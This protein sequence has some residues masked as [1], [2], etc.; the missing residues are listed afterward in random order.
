MKERVIDAVVENNLIKKGEN[1]LLGLSGGPDSMAL[2]YILKDIRE[3]IPF[4]LLAAH[5]NH[6][7]RGEDADNDENYVKDQCNKLNIPIYSQKINMNK[8]AKKNKLSSE[9]AGREIRYSF[10]RKTLDNIGGGK[11][12]VAHNKNDQAETLLMRFLRGTGIDGLR[13]MEYASNDII[14]P[15][16]DISRTEIEKYCRENEINPRIDKTNLEAIYGRNKIR[17]ELIPYIENNFNLG[18]IETLTRTARVMQ[19]ESDFLSEYTKEQFSEILIKENR[20]NIK[21]HNNKFIRLHKSIRSRVIRMG[22]ERL[23]GNLKGVEEKHVSDILDL[24]NSEN[25]GKR[26]NIGNNINIRISYKQ[27]IIEKNDKLKGKIEFHENLYLKSKL[28]IEELDM[29]IETKVI[30][31]E[32]LN[33]NSKDRFIKYFDYDKI[34]GDLS[35]R[36]RNPG[37]RFIPL[38]MKGSK[39]IKDFYID[40]KIPREDRD[41]IPLVVDNKNIIWVVG[42]RISDIYKVTE[43]TKRILEIKVSQNEY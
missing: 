9:E 31:K 24:S 26:I 8:Y 22:I 5:I 11:I 43:C 41:R 39:K 42:Y 37:D 6:G 32:D 19:T 10:F 28:N 14:R 21:L 29:T 20:N 12:A 25:T 15:L 16:L 33:F 36:N 34:N 13:G 7:I 30:N 4:N 2:L 1:I 17:L 18:I 40:E 23:K 27:L 38:G 35:V 3:I